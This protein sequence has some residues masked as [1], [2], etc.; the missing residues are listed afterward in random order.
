MSYLLKC[1]IR[2]YWL[3]IPKHK[4][5][6]CIFSESCSQYVFRITNEQGFVQ[7]LVA[8]SERFKQCRHGYI[9]Y[10]NATNQF[11]MHVKNGDTVSEHNISVKLLPP[12]RYNYIDL[13]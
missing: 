1:I 11:E 4:R 8:F 5:K 3:V 2:I 13:V 6:A 10:K 12:F 7:G 9:I